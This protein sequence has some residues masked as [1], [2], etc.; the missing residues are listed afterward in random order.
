MRAHEQALLFLKKAAEDEAL[1]PP[2]REIENFN[3]Y[4]VIFRYEEDTSLRPLDRA[5]ARQLI[6]DLRAHIEGQ[7]GPQVGP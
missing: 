5:R 2:L 7:V 4:A 6:R 1:P 3:P